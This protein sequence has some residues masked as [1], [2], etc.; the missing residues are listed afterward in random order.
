MVKTKLV[1]VA[2]QKVGVEKITTVTV[3]NL[4]VGL[5]MDGKRVLLVKDA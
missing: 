1:A 5:A 4:G 2:N 3:Y